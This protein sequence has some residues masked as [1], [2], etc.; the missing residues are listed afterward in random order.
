MATAKYPASRVSVLQWQ[1]KRSLNYDLSDLTI[2]YDYLFVIK[3]SGIGFITK[4][5]QIIISE[6]K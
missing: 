6:I 1:E 5:K 2:D 3:I 4:F